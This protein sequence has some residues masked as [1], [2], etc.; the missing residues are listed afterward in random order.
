MQTTACASGKCPKLTAPCQCFDMPVQG[1]S[2]SCPQLVSTPASGHWLHFDSSQCSPWSLYIG[3]L[4][5][6]GAPFAV[7]MAWLTTYVKVWG[8]RNCLNRSACQL[9]RRQHLCTRDAKA[10]V[11]CG[12]VRAWPVCSL[13][14]PS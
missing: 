5:S 6:V 12:V 9:A 8:I 1:S 10:L 13:S 3:S 11:L 4:T 7:W 2:L 14:L